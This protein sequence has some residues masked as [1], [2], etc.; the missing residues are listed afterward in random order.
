MVELTAMNCKEATQLSVM[1]HAKETRR[2]DRLRLYMHLLLCK[3][4]RFFDRQQTMIDHEME[5][6][7]Q[8]DQLT[9]DER[10]AMQAKLNQS[11]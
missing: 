3:Y 5:H 9:A 7:G 6:L 1:K 4:C 11:T 8:Q 2:I 10:A